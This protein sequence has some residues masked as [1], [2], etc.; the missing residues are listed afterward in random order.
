MLTKIKLYDRRPTK[1]E[2]VN[3][4]K[5]FHVAC[6]IC[7]QGRCE[8]L[9]FYSLFALASTCVARH[10]WKR[11]NTMKKLK[12]IWK[13]NERLNGV[14]CKL[15]FFTTFFLSFS[16]M[17]IRQLTKHFNTK[18]K[19]KYSLKIAITMQCNGKK[20]KEEDKKAFV[21]NENLF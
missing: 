20:W 10:R 16:L 19:H 7:N 5:Y 13:I 1:C 2:L 12:I 8:K 15:S 17:I 11:H 9:F 14:L 4:K 6:D 18:K 3:S 21:S